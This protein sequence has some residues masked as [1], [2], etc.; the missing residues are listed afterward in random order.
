MA[1]AVKLN[2]STQV[3]IEFSDEDSFELLA[4]GILKVTQDRKVTYYGV[5]YW[6]QVQTL[7]DHPSGL[8]RSAKRRRT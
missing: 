4:G 6:Q 5:G 1:F 3:G 8:M 2:D 7:N